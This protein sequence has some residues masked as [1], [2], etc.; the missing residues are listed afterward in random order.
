MSRKETVQKVIDKVRSNQA[1]LKVELVLGKVFVQKPGNPLENNSSNLQ[2]KRLPFQ[3]KQDL[4]SLVDAGKKSPMAM[5]ER[6]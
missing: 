6:E 3:L 5:H 1:L 4:A 2:T